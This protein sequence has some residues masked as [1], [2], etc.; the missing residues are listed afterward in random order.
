M[1]SRS[2]TIVRKVVL[3]V[4][5]VSSISTSPAIKKMESLS[6]EKVKSLLRLTKLVRPANYNLKLNPNLK[7]GTFSGSVNII[8]NVLEKCSNLT[9]HSKGLSIRD[10]SL[11]KGNK[12][13]AVTRFCENKE[14][15]QLMIETKECL[16]P[17]DYCLSIDFSGDLKNKIV[18]FYSS[19]YK[20][21]LIFFYL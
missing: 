15:E 18:G 10:V 17:G 20:D 11:T 14:L 1:L 7:V 2:Y 21:R 3:R 13:L 5:P 12:A 16:S 9:L 19:Q 8:I 4:L 6:S